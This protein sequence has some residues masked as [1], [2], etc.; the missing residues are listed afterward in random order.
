MCVLVSDH[1]DLPAV[2]M[3]NHAYQRFADA[4]WDLVPASTD[5][6]I[7]KGSKVAAEA[8]AHHGSCV[9][10]PNTHELPISLKM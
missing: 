10:I 5:L 9:C 6:K 3:M 4:V 2:L 1:G 7:T 8:H